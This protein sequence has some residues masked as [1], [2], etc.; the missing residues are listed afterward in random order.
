M[1]VLIEYSI[2]PTDKGESVSSYVSRVID[3]IRKSGYPYKFTAMGTIVETATIREAMEL[4][5]KSYDLLEVDC[6]RVYASIKLDIRKG[7]DNR[8]EGK[9][10]SVEEK[11]GQVRT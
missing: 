7:K 4:V 2:F 10:K 6:N 1:S 5:A 11:I 8:L 9:I 3:M